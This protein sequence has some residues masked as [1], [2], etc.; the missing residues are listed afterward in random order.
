MERAREYVAAWGSE[1]SDLGDA[2]HINA[3]S[4]LGTWP[5]GYGLLQG[6]RRGGGM[7]AVR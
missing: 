1:L 4:G 6:L 5:V 3:S 7:V 2:G